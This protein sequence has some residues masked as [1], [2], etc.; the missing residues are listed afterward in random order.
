MIAPHIAHPNALIL[1]M[2]TAFAICMVEK[3]RTRVF[4]PTSSGASGCQT[5]FGLKTSGDPPW[6]ASWFSLVILT[7]QLQE[8]H[9]AGDKNVHYSTWLV[10]CVRRGAARLMCADRVDTCGRRFCVEVA[11]RCFSRS[12][13][14]VSRCLFVRHSPYISPLACSPRPWYMYSSKHMLTRIRAYI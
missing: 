12:R 1:S 4:P 6:P 5:G 10:V 14:R 7:A 13:Q 2:R 9:P 11:P 3:N 8:S